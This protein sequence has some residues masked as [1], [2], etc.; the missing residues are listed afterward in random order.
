[1]KRKVYITLIIFMVMINSLIMAACG[2]KKSS[3][4]ELL[5]DESPPPQDYGNETQITDNNNTIMHDTDNLSFGIPDNAKP[6]N[7]LPPLENH[8]A[9]ATYFFTITDDYLVWIVNEGPHS[10]YRMYV[11]DDEGKVVWR[12]EKR[13]FPSEADAEAFAATW[14]GYIQIGNV[15]YIGDPSAQLDEWQGAQTK[16]FQINF[17]AN[18]YEL[19]Y[20]S[21]PL[22]TTSLP[23]NGN[24]L[25]APPPFETHVGDQTYFWQ[26]ED[27]YIV[28]MFHTGGYLDSFDMDSYVEFIEY[29]L[30]F[31]GLNEFG[32]TYGVQYKWIL[33]NEEVAIKFAESTPSYIVIENVV[34]S[35]VTGWHGDNREEII[36]NA[37]RVVND[38]NGAIYISKP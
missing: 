31:E 20:I 2:G 17:I 10:I 28:W 5:T 38:F 6:P 25:D 7:V 16:E 37:K 30:W 4:G 1:M 11:F 12:S 26:R 13:V 23:I 21:M 24:P 9:D 19:Y 34:Y 3:V 8:P 14:L 27:D 35:T 36:E 33:E 22:S 18:E 29:R 32:R 15:V